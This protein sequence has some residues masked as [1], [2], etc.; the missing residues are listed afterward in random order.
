MMSWSGPPVQTLGTDGMWVNDVTH[1]LQDSAV[2]RKL[3]TPSGLG[4]SG[5]P[6]LSFNHGLMRYKSK[7]GRFGFPPSRVSVIRLPSA[8]HPCNLD[9]P[10][11]FARR[12]LSLAA[13][14]P[15]P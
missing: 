14:N 3:L 4:D 1:P 8:A 11:R 5:V 15:K 7:L 12:R 13:L 2:S 9:P 10:P 6:L